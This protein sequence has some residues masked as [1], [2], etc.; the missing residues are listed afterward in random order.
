MGTGEGVGNHQRLFRG[1]EEREG[2]K[3]RIPLPARTGKYHHLAADAAETKGKGG[4]NDL[5]KK[6]K[7]K[8]A[9]AV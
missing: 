1:K 5:I 8:G 6:G 4:K 3:G 9:L 7:E 2:K